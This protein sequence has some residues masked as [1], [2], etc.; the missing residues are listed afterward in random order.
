VRGV[1]A[2][3]AIPAGVAVVATDT[4]SAIKG[5]QALSV[6]W[7]PGPGAGLST[8]SIFA[9]YR[10][11]AKKPGAVARN[12][13]D[14]V[15]ALAASAKRIAAEFEVPYLAHAPMEPLNCVVQVKE[16]GCDIWTGDQFQT[17]DQR[18]AAKVL[19]IAPEKVRIHTMFA[20]GSFGRR[21][22]TQSD[23]IVEGVA[24]AKHMGVPVKTMW[25]REDD[26]H[27]G[28]Y[29]PCYLHT[30]EAGLDDTGHACCLETPHRRPVHRRRHALRGRHGEERRR[31]HLGGRCLQPALCHSQPAR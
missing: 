23:Y 6:E 15:K 17:G 27:G 31:P 16:G 21:A 2:V 14:A 19:G 10:D 25:T 12:D 9:S 7:E 22:N 1:K 29:R 30:L 8:E 5:R 11:L 24:I 3:F 28:F 26:I 4:W 20:G 18:N 13:G